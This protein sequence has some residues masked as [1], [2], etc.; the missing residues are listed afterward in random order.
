MSHSALLP[1][2]V[3]GDKNSLSPEARMAIDKLAARRPRQFL[4][5]LVYA[6]AVI[7]VAIALAVVA[8]NV[9]VSI[10]AIMAVASRFFVFSLL[11]HEQAHCLAFKS[12]WGDLW[13]N[14]LVAYP[15][16]IATVDGYAQVHLAHHRFFFTEKD[17]DIVRKSGEDWTF[18]MAKTKLAK[19]F[20][21]DLFA[22]NVWKMVKGKMAVTNYGLFKRP[23][24]IPAWFRPSYYIVLVSVLTISH[25]W[26]A[27]FLYWM[28]PILTVYQ[29][30]ARF[31][32]LCEHHYVPNANVANTSPIIIPFWWENI[33]LPN[34]NFNL[35]PYHHFF[36]GIAFCD[37]PAVHE[38]FRQ[39][40]LVDE[41]AIF[42]GYASYLKH[43][44][45]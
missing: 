10:L 11:I 18:P 36:P 15:L 12:K 33:L 32:A 25:A 24:H 44:I 27:F 4:L 37:L 3:L 39:E 9:W 20:L 23:A 21:A 19:L 7:I 42:K 14:A 34:L 13:V 31:G 30:M 28:V 29:V 22:L 8:Q 41:T 45:R 2:A 5:Q 1:P 43:L 38:I 6:W 35:H 26:G 16:L 17:P 40:G